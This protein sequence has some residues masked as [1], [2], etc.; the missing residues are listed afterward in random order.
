MQPD[1]IRP[2]A[3]IP[4]FAFSDDMV[5]FQSKVFAFAHQY[6]RPKRHKSINCIIVEIANNSRA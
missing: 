5:Q 2:A 3:R 6:L 1:S 4:N